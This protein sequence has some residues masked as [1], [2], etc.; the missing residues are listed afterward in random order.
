[1]LARR[2]VEAVQAL[3]EPHRSSCVSDTVTISVGAACCIPKA[4]DRLFSLI[5]AA[6]QALYQAKHDGRN[7][8]VI[9]SAL[10]G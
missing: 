4:D 10:E 9:S 8:A 1:M 6:D 5:E 3:A 2:A 7:R